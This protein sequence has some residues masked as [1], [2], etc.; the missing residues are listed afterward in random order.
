MHGGDHSFFVGGEPEALLKASSAVY[1]VASRTDDVALEVLDAVGS[2]L[3]TVG[4][5]ALFAPGRAAAVAGALRDVLAA[6][7]AGLPTVAAAYHGASL[8]LRHTGQALEAAGAVGLVA[9]GALRLLRGERPTVL[10]SADGVDLQREV[11]TGSWSVGSGGS[12]SSLAVRE[13]RAPD[14]TTFFVVE[15]TDGSRYAESL[16]AQVNGVGAFVDAGAGIERTLRW[17]VPTRRDA[18]LLL[19]A[20]SGTL[21]LGGRGFSLLPKPTETVHGLAGSATA[22]GGTASATL[23]VR[24]E[25]TSLRSGGQRLTSSFSGVGQASVPAVPGL[26]G[27]GGAASAKVTVDRNPGGAVSKISLTTTTVVDRG[28]H[29]LPLLEAANREATL[30]ERQWEVRITPEGRAAA[31]RIASAA[32]KGHRPDAKDL[33]ALAG[34]VDSTRPTERTYDVRHQQASVDVAVRWVDGG[35]GAGLDKAEL[36]SERKPHP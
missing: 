19:A 7:G 22:V 27:T 6:P 18:E 25:V 21:A 36:V 16:G 20:A 31:D 4:T 24:H 33:E 5:M 1:E 9:T 17:A 30:V 35:G 14:G 23:S 34:G 28:R 13:V 26:G 2:A 11:L 15:A 29:G 32:T 8:L 12:S 10:A 3:T